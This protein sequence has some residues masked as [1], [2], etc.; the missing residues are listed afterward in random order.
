MAVKKRFGRKRVAKKRVWKKRGYKTVTTKGSLTPLPQRFIT[1]HK[2]AEVISSA[3]GGGT[4]GTCRLNLNSIYDPNQSGGG[5]QVMMFDQLSALYNRYRVI[6]CSYRISCAVSDNT[7]P[8]QVALVPSNET[9][10]SPSNIAQI[11]E[12][13]RAKYVLQGAGANIRTISGYV[14]LPSLFGRTKA[15]YMADDRYQST[16]TTSP[17]ELAVL[18]C[19]AGLLSE[20]SSTATVYFNIELNYHVEWFDIQPQAQS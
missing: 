12:S 8:L 20:G 4:Y 3:L 19:F 5:H 17:S 15:Q 11:R 6:G 2:Y 16:V 18:N 13:P 1:K 14:S 10:P 7:V 9:I